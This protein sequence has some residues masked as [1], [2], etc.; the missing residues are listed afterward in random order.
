M[1]H[2]DH[3]IHIRSRFSKAHEIIGGTV[4]VPATSVSYKGVRDNWDHV[5]IGNLNSYPS[6]GYKDQLMSKMRHNI[7]CCFG[8]HFVQPSN[9]WCLHKISHNESRQAKYKGSHY[10]YDECWVLAFEVAAYQKD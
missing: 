4:D 10:W 9:Q 5:M 7:G 2:V 1:I 6:G 8:I 3:E